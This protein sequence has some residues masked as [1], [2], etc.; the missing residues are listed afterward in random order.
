MISPYLTVEEAYLL[1]KLI[2]GIDAEA[3]LVLGPV[4][5]VGEDER[6]PKGIHD[7]AEKCPNRR[8]VEAIIAHF[9]QRVRRL[10]NF[11]RS[12]TAGRCKAF[13]W[14]ADIRRRLD[15]RAHGPAVRAAEVAGGAGLVPFAAVGTRDARV[16]GRRLCR[17][18]RLVRQ[19][20]RPAA[21]GRLGDPPAGGRSGRGEPAIGNCSAGKG[22]YNSR[23]VLEEI[24]REILY[25]SAV[26][27]PV[28]ETGIDLQVESGGRMT[29]DN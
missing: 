17:A 28:P 2:R 10:M 24:A 4:P 3:M 11:C 19:L 16:A 23:D 14:P 27:G 21:I 22:L 20:A 15:R 8:G 18:R 6:F 5:V 1:C 7:P 26:V 9:A 12:W 13:G 29:E 25:F